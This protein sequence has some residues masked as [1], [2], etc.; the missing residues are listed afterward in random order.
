MPPK[1][2]IGNI[3]PKHPPFPKRNELDEG[4]LPLPAGVIYIHPPFLSHTPFH[5]SALGHRQAFLEGLWTYAPFTVPSCAVSPQHAV[6]KQSPSGISNVTSTQVSWARVRRERGVA[7]TRVPYPFL[8]PCHSPWHFQVK[9][10]APKMVGRPFIIPSAYNP[11]SSTPARSLP[12]IAIV[13]IVTVLTLG[14]NPRCIDSSN[15]VRKLKPQAQMKSFHARASSLD[16]CFRSRAK[17]LVA[18]G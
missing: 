7:A 2:S 8:R 14:H 3:K 10:M 11:H 5:L 4:H 16:L 6:V 1:I 13:L 17:G 15:H 18:S 12:L 9:A